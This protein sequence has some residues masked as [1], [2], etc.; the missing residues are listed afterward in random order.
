MIRVLAVDDQS[1]VRAGLR[2]ILSGQVDIALVGEAA[3]GE[4]AI[5]AAGRL[6]PDV[7]LMD[8]RMPHMDG[9]EATRKIVGAPGTAHCKV[10][11][12][13]TFDVED[14]VYE[15]IRGGASGFLLKEAPPSR[16]SQRYA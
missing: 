4:Q 10:L 3:D 8:I 5:E 11:A 6:N 15:A 13:T 2:V 7:I 9:L 12:L 14:Y 16:S 1:L